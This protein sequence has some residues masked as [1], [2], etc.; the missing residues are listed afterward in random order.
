MGVST[1]DVIALSCTDYGEDDT[2]T[3]GGAV[4]NS[5][6]VEIQ[7]DVG[8]VYEILSDADASGATVTVRHRTP[9]GPIRE[10]VLSVSTTPTPIFGVGNNSD[11]L[12]KIHSSAILGATTIRSQTGP[13]TIA[14]IDTLSV[15]PT[16]RAQRRLF[17]NSAAS[18]TQQKIFY[19][20]TFWR[21]FSGDT[22]ISPRYQLSADPDSLIKH[23]IAL[24]IG[25]SVSTDKNVA[26][27]GIIFVD[28]G[29]DQNGNDLGGGQ[30]QGIWWEMTAAIQ[31][32]PVKSFFTSQVSYQS[33]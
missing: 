25:D 2:D 20:K 26:P 24:S 18:Y 33:I 14:V 3:T 19:D 15:N 21:N 17:P 27:S 1:S 16:I 13:I 31:N 30:A 29:V 8:G 10:D 28:D 4:D 22:M 23:G 6:G 32:P 5:T 12:L 9:D 11:R 7:N